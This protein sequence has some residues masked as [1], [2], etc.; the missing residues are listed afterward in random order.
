[1]IIIIISYYEPVPRPVGEVTNDFKVLRVFLRSRSGGGGGG[2]GR[3][4]SGGG[5]CCRS[6]VHRFCR[7]RRGRAIVM[8]RDRSNRRRFADDRHRRGVDVTCERA[9]IYTADTQTHR[10]VHNNIL[11]AANNIKVYTRPG[12]VTSQQSIVVHHR[13][14]CSGEGV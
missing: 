3:S 4:R 11:T 6:R 13:L 7:S 12:D 5:R 14:V 1:M 9:R 8:R 2:G 10:R